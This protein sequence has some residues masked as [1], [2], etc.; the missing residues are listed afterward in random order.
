MKAKP[1]SQCCSEKRGMAQNA[2]GEGEGTERDNDQNFSLALGV[3]N[4]EGK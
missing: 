2:D 3:P 4:K 1:V